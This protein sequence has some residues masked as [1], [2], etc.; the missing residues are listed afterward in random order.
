[1]SAIAFCDKVSGHVA[2]GRELMQWIIAL[3]SVLSVRAGNPVAEQHP[4]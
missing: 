3:L 2:E 1:M 4:F